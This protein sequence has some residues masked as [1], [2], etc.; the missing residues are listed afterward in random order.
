MRR[1]PDSQLLSGKNNAQGDRGRLPEDNVWD[2]CLTR[3]LEESPFD[4]FSSREPV[5]TSDQVRGRLSL[6]N[7]LKTL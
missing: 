6:E 1:R 5:S 4:A 2:V 3:M 7:A